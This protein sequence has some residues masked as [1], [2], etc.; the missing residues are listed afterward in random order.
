[1]YRDKTMWTQQ[2][3]SHLQAKKRGCIRNQ[4]CWYLPLGFPAYRIVRKNFALCKPG[5]VVMAPFI[6]S[7]RWQIEGLTLQELSVS[8]IQL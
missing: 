7:C 4:T 1:M 5:Y 2:K 6:N 3:D 8:K